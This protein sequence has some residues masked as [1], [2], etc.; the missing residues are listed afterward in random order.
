VRLSRGNVSCQ[1]CR[2]TL[3]PARQLQVVAVLLPLPRAR[4]IHAHITDGQEQPHVAAA[5]QLFGQG[6][7]GGG[8]SKAK[9][10]WLLW[11]TPIV[12]GRRILQEG[13]GNEQLSDVHAQHTCREDIGRHACHKVVGNKQPPVVDER[14]PPQEDVGRLP[15]GSAGTCPLTVL[16][17]PTSSPCRLILRWGDSW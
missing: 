15:P 16:P 4:N 10:R 14:L 13:I 17:Q 3:S 9:G 8:G 1:P 2:P 6:G 12:P 7:F 5:V 11:R